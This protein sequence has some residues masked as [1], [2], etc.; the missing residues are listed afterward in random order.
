MVDRAELQRQQL[1][2]IRYQEVRDWLS[3]E[4]NW[5]TE[6]RERQRASTALQQMQE[7]AAYKAAVREWLDAEKAWLD[8][9][10]R[11][12]LDAEQAWLDDQQAK[13]EAQRR[14]MTGPT[15]DELAARRARAREQAKAAA[16]AKRLNIVAELKAPKT[17]AT[18]L[19]RQRMRHL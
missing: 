18:E 16:A 8:E 12:W 3:A 10:L 2:E 11:D 1:A 7:A 5:K 6:Q 17:K 15:D 14:Q 13:L 9:E 19:T 4:R